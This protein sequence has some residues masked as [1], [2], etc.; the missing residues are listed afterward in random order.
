MAKTT[1]DR[2]PL[3]CF[4]FDGT[5][6]DPSSPGCMNAELA[7]MLE[8][9]R[10]QGA[11]FVIN[12]GRSL[13]DAVSG[14]NRIGLRDFP[15]YL[16]TCEREIHEP[17]AFRRWVDF[18]NWNKRCRRDHEKLFHRHRTLLQKIKD[19]VE[20]QSRAQWIA[21]PEEPAGIIAGSNGEMDEF[22][23][24]IDQLIRETGARQ[25]AYERNTIYLRFSHSKY[26]KGSALQ[27]IANKLKI[28]PSKTF[29][30]GDNYNDL[31]MLQEKAASMIA[32]PGNSIPEIKEEITR[33]GGYVSS[34]ACGAG[35]AEAI[36]HFF[37]V[38]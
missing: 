36:A 20:G 29:A 7:G 22:C 34:K 1:K 4:D 27:E 13:F 9:L 11:L 10:E 5:F 18:G 14:I 12:T 15:D 35:V 28:S 3:L 21:Q 17:N 16:V 6:I 23:L 37:A 24:F 31:T 19:F 2:R 26:N 30:I 25:L 38:T 32:C 8:H 33:R